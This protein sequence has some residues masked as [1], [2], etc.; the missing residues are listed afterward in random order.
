M[1]QQIG[2]QNPKDGLEYRDRHQADD[3]HI[4]RAERM[5]QQHLANDDLEEQGA[6]G[7]SVTAASRWAF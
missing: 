2:A 4:E 5:V 7:R 1:R 3:Q 6:L